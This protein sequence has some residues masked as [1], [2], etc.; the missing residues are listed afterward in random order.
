MVDLLKGLIMK[1]PR[2]TNLSATEPFSFI[3][4]HAPWQGYDFVRTLEK[5][6]TQ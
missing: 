6:S 2:R 4:I 1:L 5:T 3:L